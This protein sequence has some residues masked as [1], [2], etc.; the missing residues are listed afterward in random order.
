ME[1]KYFEYCGEKVWV[2]KPNKYEL[3]KMKNDIITGLID[4]TPTS[5]DFNVDTYEMFMKL[6]PILTNIR[7]KGIGAKTELKYKIKND[8]KELEAIFY[9]LKEILNEAIILFVKELQEGE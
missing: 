6:F 4:V 3:D 2:E 8:D 1:K 9:E 5:I 7:I